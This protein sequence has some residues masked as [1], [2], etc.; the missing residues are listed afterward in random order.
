MF[1]YLPLIWMKPTPFFFFF[2]FSYVHIR[3]FFTSS[4]FCNSVSLFFFFLGFCFLFNELGVYQ[5]CEL[6]VLSVARFS[7]PLSSPTI[8]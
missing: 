1:F 4:G 2:V 3:S 6:W 8:N 5:L 7:G